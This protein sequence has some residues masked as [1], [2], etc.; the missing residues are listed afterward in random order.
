MRDGRSASQILLGFLPQQTVD[1]RGR[2]WK[3][4][5]WKQPIRQE[6]DTAALRREL[7]RLSAA[8]QTV[9]TDGGFSTDLLAGSE[10][11]VYGL[12]REI[13]VLVEPF[14]KLWMCREC[15]EVARTDEQ[16][17]VNC[18]HLKWGQLPFVGF[19]GACG[20]LREPWIPTCR[21]HSRLRVIL[22][23]TSS[24]AEIR[25]E[26]PVC[27]VLIRKGFGFVPCP[28]GN[29]NLS[30]NVHRAA[31]VF[32]PRGVVV[33]NPPS[34]AQQKR[35]MEAGG[36][37]RACEWVLGGFTEPSAD[38]V[39][40]TAA[41]LAQMLIGQGLPKD[42]VDRMVKSAVDSGAVR[43]QPTRT[44]LDGS[45]REEAE[46]EAVGIALAL[47]ESRRRIVDLSL[48]AQS[49]ELKDLYERRYPEALDA[50]GL[51]AIEFTDGLPVLAGQFAFTRGDSTPGTTRLM[52]FRFHDAYVVYGD[53]SKAEALFIRLR[54]SRVASW[55]R[56]LGF[57]L[58]DWIDEKSARVSILNAMRRVQNPGDEC[59]W[60]TVIRAVYVLVHSYAHRVIRRIAVFAGTERTSLSEILVPTHC[61]FFVYAAARGDFVLGGLQAVFEGELDRFLNDLVDG[62]HRC[63]L[64]PGCSRN[65]S[66]CMACLHVGE[67][68]CRAFNTDLSRSALDGPTGFLGA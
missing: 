27:G 46:T 4:K 18:R 1:L 33:V 12:N 24:A 6:V 20:A 67:A 5:D 30:F 16:P 45:V 7:L 9:G 22:P 28:C 53:V 52:P 38:T 39:E 3:V 13:G 64:D 31:S 58:E 61:S 25:F 56:R 55:L 62:E 40:L 41:E 49:V 48:L 2:I 8:W 32:T 15:H 17:C 11:R 21:A 63:P 51:E 50:A 35:L 57:T 42:A 34:A 60:K 10:I 59:P 47:Q 29:G 36:A 37:A 23:G 44:V 66:A 43:E 19:H 65:G 54:P 68:S 26:C 14:P